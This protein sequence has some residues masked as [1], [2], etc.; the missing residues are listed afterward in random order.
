MATPTK[1]HTRRS[2]ESG[3]DGQPRKNRTT[4]KPRDQE[5]SSRHSESSGKRVEGYYGL[6]NDCT[7]V[8]NCCNELNSNLGQLVLLWAQDT[9]ATI[10]AA[11]IALGAPAVNQIL[12]YVQPFNIITA[13]KARDAFTATISPECCSGYATGVRDGLRGIVFLAIRNSFIPGLT[14]MQIQSNLNLALSEIDKLI[15]AEKQN[16][17]CGLQPT[18][19]PCGS[20]CRDPNCG[21]RH[22]TKF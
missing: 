21:K 20:T 14:E 4:R 16:A 19:K 6:M 9:A 2:S 13:A 7:P 22:F 1:K 15:Q 5:L 11:I 8:C 10:A 17:Q 3:S 18:C 12:N